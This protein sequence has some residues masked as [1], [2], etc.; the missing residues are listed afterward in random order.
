MGVGDV[1]VAAAGGEAL[2]G[3]PE[4]GEPT[5]SPG[6][7]FDFDG[8]YGEKYEALARRLIPGYRTLF[9]MFA[10]LIEP[11]LPRGARVLVVG[12]GTGIEIVNLKRARPD[13]RVHGVDP[14]A[15]MLALAERRVAKAVL[16]DGVTFHLGYAADLAPAPV[17][18]AAT[19][20]NVLHFLPD[21]GSKAALLADIARR[22]RPGGVFVLFD[23]HGG[24]TPE[25]HE[26][27]LS[28]WRRYWRVRGMTP[29][30]MR[31][32]D[33]RIREGIHFVPASR[34]VELAREAGLGEARRFY[35]SLLYGGWTFRRKGEVR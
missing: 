16:E 12:A 4:P 21:D 11:E 9:P 29:D 8:E 26:H 22:L 1:P 23:L 32:F 13:L 3:A 31:A 27:H 33:E 6:E 5:S 30:E 10:A 7:V 14:S 2:S 28:A 17:F 25:E 19:L 18:D 34:A 15:R 20:F 35:K 24:A